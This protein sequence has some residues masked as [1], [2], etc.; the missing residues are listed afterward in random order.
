MSDQTLAEAEFLQEV[1]AFVREKWRRNPCGRCGTFQWSVLPGSANVLVI[2][3]SAPRDPDN[4]GHRLYRSI[5]KDDAEFIPLYCDNCGN[6]VAIY[7][8][9]FDEWR[10]ANR[11]TT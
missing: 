8:K 1:Q 9:V 5:S 2:G 10:K 11:R 4:R 6:T 3:V 7:K